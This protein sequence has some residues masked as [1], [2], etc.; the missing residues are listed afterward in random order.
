MRKF[1]IGST[2]VLKSGGPLMTVQDYGKILNPD[3]LA[4][5]EKPEEVKCSWFEGEKKCSDSFHPDSLVESE[6]E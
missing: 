2:V 6:L 4:W 1:E 5:E 3:T